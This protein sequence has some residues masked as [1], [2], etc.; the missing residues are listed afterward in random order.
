MLLA[1]KDDFVAN[2]SH[3]FRTPLTAIQSYIALA[4]E[5]PGLHPQE[6]VQLFENC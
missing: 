1:A 4:L 6:V 5:A 3:E 2:V